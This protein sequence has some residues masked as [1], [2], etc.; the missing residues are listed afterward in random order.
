MGGFFTVIY[1]QTKGEWLFWQNPP[2][3]GKDD[4]ISFMPLAMF[5]RFYL[6]L[7]K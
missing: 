3:Q 1:F 5:I 2:G 7:R 6:V 4:R